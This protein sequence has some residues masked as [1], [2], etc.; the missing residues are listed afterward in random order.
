MDN[1][2]SLI[3]LF[4]IGLI[5]ITLIDTL[6]A[7][8]SRKFNFKYTYLSILS[9]AVYMGI[10]YFLSNHFQLIIIFATNSLLGLYDSTIGL[11]LSIRL[12]A[13]SENI[14]TVE[15]NAKMVIS[16]IIV[17]VFFGFIGYSVNGYLGPD[18]SR[19]KH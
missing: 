8:A 1:Y 2:S 9:F 10:G 12:K 6:G 15:S 19:F 3:S 11:K 16:M 4:L 5:C 14:D 18:H 7:V 17:A 13:N